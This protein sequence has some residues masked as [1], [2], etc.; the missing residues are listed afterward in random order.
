VKKKETIL[1]KRETKELSIPIRKLSA[2][3]RKGEK[4]KERKEF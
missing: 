1:G 2:M 3:I 4:D